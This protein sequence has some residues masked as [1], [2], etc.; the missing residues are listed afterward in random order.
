MKPTR[1]DIRA[2]FV[3]VLG[4][5]GDEWEDLPEVTDDTKIMGNL[6][7]RSIELAYLANAT[8]SHYQQA[9]PFTEFLQSIEARDEQ[10]IT[11]REWVDFVYQNMSDT[12]TD[13]DLNGAQ[14]TV[15]NPVN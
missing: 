8:Q 9:F 12:E 13:P 11:V 1:D 4:S 14:P 7:W 6:N 15:G 10:D 2:H 3:G 5:M